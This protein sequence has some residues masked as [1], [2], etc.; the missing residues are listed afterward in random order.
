MAK[1]TK[2]EVSC[3]LMR[4]ATGATAASA[5]KFAFDSRFRERH[6][7]HASSNVCSRVFLLLAL[8]FLRAAVIAQYYLMRGENARLRSG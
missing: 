8:S 5:L 2:S 7:M 4:R 6:A 3:N 1:P